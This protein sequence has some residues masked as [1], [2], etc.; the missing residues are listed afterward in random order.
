MKCDHEGMCDVSTREPPGLS[1]SQ[2]DRLL[3]NRGLHRLKLDC[4]DLNMDQCPGVSDNTALPAVEEASRKDPWAAGCDASALPGAGGPPPWLCI[5][6]HLCGAATDYALRACLGAAP[7]GGKRVQQQ[8]EQLLVPQQPQSDP[9][10]AG[11]DGGASWRRL[12]GLAIAPCCHH[13]CGWRA[14]VGKPL[15]RRLGFTGEEFELMSWMTGWA[16]CGHAGGRGNAACEGGDEDGGSSEYSDEECGALGKATGSKQSR[17]RGRDGADA[18]IPR[19]APV[20]SSGCS[21]PFHAP[22]LDC[23]ARSPKGD[24]ASAYQSASAAPATSQA[25]LED[26]PDVSTVPTT[27]QAQSEDMPAVSAA[28]ATSTAA[29]S[30]LITYSADLP[31]ER[32]VAVGQMCKQLI[33]QGR[34]EWLKGV[35]ACGQ[36]ELVS[37]CRPEVSGECRLLLALMQ[38]RSE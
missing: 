12:H 19:P 9:P 16:L 17:K 25:Q 29:S 6:K 15:F 18:D 7:R 24:V 23:E 20:R 22:S 33:D 11:L 38:G 8:Q 36:T 28:P 37:Y 1:S 35:G 31:R 21:P 34:L 14:F 10:Q 2:A 3:R 26:M 32:R 30:A 5:G 27:S 4:K 13:R